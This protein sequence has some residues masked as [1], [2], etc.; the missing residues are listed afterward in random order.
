MFEWFSLSSTKIEDQQKTIILP[1][2]S[3]SI[4]A[5]NKIFVQLRIKWT[6][7]FMTLDLTIFL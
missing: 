5:A 7:D 4:L 2:I 1:V 6:Q 3:N